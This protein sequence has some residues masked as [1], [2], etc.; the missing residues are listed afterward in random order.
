[1]MRARTQSKNNRRVGPPA[2]LVILSIASLLSHV[3]FGDPP[4]EKQSQ[5]LPT[6][7]QLVKKLEQQNEAL[8]QQAKQLAEQERRLEEYRAALERALAD[9]RLRLRELELQRGTGTKITGVRDASGAATN[10]PVGESETTKRKKPGAR[11]DVAQAQTDSD[12]PAPDKPI[13]QAPEAAARPP[14]IAQITEF[15]GVLTPKGKF[16]FEP[17]LQY[18]HSSNDRV[19]LTGFA[20]IPALVIGAIDIRSVNRDLWVA[21]LTGRYGLTD[22]LEVEAKVPYV[23][24]Q[25]STTAR[26]L[27][28]PSFFDS[29]FNSDGKGLGDV[30]LTARYQL[31][32]GGSDTP[33]YVGSLRLKTVTGKGPFE[34]P[35]TELFPGFLVQT[36]L[37]TGTGFYALQP[38]ITALFPSD[39]A[40]FFAGASY[41]W[42]IKRN[43]NDIDGTRISYDPGDAVTVNFGMGLS[44]NDRASFSVG[45]EHDVFFKDKRN[46]EYL[47]N[48]KSEHLGTLLIGYSYRLTKKTTFNLTLGVGVTP[49][50]PD[51]QLT[52]RLPIMF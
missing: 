42:S 12:Q 29:V 14:E 52:V 25:D 19:A 34:V 40:V 23:Y 46:G 21:A 17:S 37:P 36:D 9:Q 2:R 30:E 20:I 15:P 3:A 32:K 11:T 5:P 28:A 26:Q 10:S 6:V 51:V 4:A 24:R 47:L 22:R 38:A 16:V 35:T 33:F 44:L 41:I 43:V 49:E 48:T 1:M 18:A 7:E 50:A 45:Y 13:G 39:P 31:N 27:I 8:A